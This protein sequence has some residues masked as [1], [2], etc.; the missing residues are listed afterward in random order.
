MPPVT[1][2][3]QPMS[4]ERAQPVLDRIALARLIADGDHLPEILRAY[5]DQDQ[6]FR[7]M[8]GLTGWNDDDHCAS[9]VTH[10]TGNKYVV[11]L[12][13]KFMAEHGYVLRKD[14]QLAGARDIET[15]LAQFEQKER[16]V[17]QSMIESAEQRRANAAKTSERQGK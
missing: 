13:L 3:F 11:E 6:L 12:F 8:H 10:I 17:R 14:P 4:A 9:D 16:E 2:E 7:A 5:D 15:S 1:V